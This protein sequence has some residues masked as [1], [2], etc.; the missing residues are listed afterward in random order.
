MHLKF[1]D[2]HAIFDGWRVNRGARG[3]VKTV[4]PLCAIKG[5]KNQK[6][7]KN[8]NNVKKSGKNKK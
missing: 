2:A 5:L 4:V 8:R 1:V 7:E 6:S 3:C